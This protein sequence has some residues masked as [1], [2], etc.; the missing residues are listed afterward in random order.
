MTMTSP[1]LPN[2]ETPLLRQLLD[3]IRANP[4][5][6]SAVRREL[7]VTDDDLLTCEQMAPRF[8]KSSKTIERWCRAGRIPTARKIGR[9]WMMPPDAT[10]EPLQPVSLGDPAA[11]GRRG[12]RRPLASDDAG[13]S[14]LAQLGRPARTQSAKAA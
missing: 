3:E 1:P 9:S 12:G 6:A 14:A 11:P 4:T 10:V 5:V 2:T 7:A 13:R 8:G